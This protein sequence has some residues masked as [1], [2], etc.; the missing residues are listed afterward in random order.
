MRK[1]RESES[2]C[3]GHISKSTSHSSIQSFCDEPEQND[4]EANPVAAPG[5]QSTATLNG[6]NSTPSLETTNYNSSNNYHSY[7]QPTKHYNHSNS[8]PLGLE[9]TTCGDDDSTSKVSMRLPVQVNHDS[10]LY[11]LWE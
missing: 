4:A 8:T 5:M 10:K 7:N 3:S 6:C 9:T 1:L 11:P 2:T